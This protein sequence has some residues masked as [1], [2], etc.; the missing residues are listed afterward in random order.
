MVG[1]TGNYAATVISVEAL[2][3]QLARILKAVDAAGGVALITADHGN[4]DEMYE[5]DKK[6]NAK[7]NADG[8]YKAKTSHTLN[9][10]PCI[11]YDNNYADAYTLKEGADFGLANVA[12]TAVNLLGGHLIN[13][14]SLDLCLSGNCELNCVGLGND[15]LLLRS[16]LTGHKRV[17]E[18]KLKILTA[19][20]YLVTYTDYKKNFLVSGVNAGNHV[21]KESTG[22]TVYALV[23]FFISGTLN[24]DLVALDLNGHS[25]AEGLSKGADGTLG[26][27]GVAVNRYCYT[28]GDFDRHSTNS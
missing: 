19:L 4:A 24:E 26:G 16:S 10:V 15:E 6:G 25:L 8:S 28:C 20:N 18:V 27:Y 22:K 5:T 2:D 17:T 14:L 1:H 21:L 13:T 12:A 9:P 11:I 23:L 3:V 7:K